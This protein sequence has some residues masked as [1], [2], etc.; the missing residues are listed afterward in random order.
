MPTCDDGGSKRKNISVYMTKRMFANVD[1]MA[2]ELGINKSQLIR[3]T[4]DHFYRE[5]QDFYGN[6]KEVFRK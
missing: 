6:R 5:Y 3:M 2:K 1:R 4:I